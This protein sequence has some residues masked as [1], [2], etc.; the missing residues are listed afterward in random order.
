MIKCARGYGSILRTC[1]PVWR[2]SWQRVGVL[3]EGMISTRDLPREKALTRVQAGERGGPAISSSPLLLPFLPTLTHLTLPTSAREVFLK[4]TFVL[5]T[6]LKPLTEKN[7]KELW[8]I[9][10]FGERDRQ[11]KFFFFFILCFSVFIFSTRTTSA[12]KM[13]TEVISLI[14][15]LDTSLGDYVFLHTLLWLSAAIWRKSQLLS[16]CDLPSPLPFFF[17]S[18]LILQYFSQDVWNDRSM[19]QNNLCSWLCFVL[20]GF[21]LTLT[22]LVQLTWAGEHCPTCSVSIFYLTVLLGRQCL[23]LSFHR[24]ENQDERG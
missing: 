19:T 8:M 20:V 6:Y 11:R 24:E 9:L 14:F 18:Q 10:T 23:F 22:F 5:V 13:S 4:F 16:K 15:S 17:Q 2:G 1:G 12:F 21:I 3:P 7:H